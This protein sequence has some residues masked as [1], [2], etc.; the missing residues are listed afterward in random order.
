MARSASFARARLR[1]RPLDRE[2]LGQQQ[3]ARHAAEQVLEAL[4]PGGGEHARLLGARQADEAH[5]C[6]VSTTLA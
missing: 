1:K 3:L 2:R 5:A 6:A 4:D